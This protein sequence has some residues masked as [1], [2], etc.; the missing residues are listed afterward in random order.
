MKNNKYYLGALELPWEDD[1][2][3]WPMAASANDCGT[4][5][6]R[7]SENLLYCELLDDLYANEMNKDLRSPYCTGC[8]RFSWPS[9]WPQLRKFLCNVVHESE[10]IA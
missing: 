8:Q 7:S 3:L 5:S 9:R 4:P 1:P 6:R 10:W 2:T